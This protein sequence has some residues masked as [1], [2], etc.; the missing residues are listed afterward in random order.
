MATPCTAIRSANNDSLVPNSLDHTQRFLHHFASER[1]FHA[2]SRVT[3]TE[4]L[5]SSIETNRTMNFTERRS[6]WR[7]Q[8]IASDTDATKLANSGDQPGRFAQR[9]RV[10]AT[11]P[12]AEFKRTFFILLAA[13]VVAQGVTG[14]LSGQ[15]K[16]TRAVVAGPLSLIAGLATVTLATMILGRYVRIG[17]RTFR[18]IAGI[19]AAL[20]TFIIYTGSAVRLTGSGLGCPDWPTCEKGQVVPESGVHAQIEFGNRVVTGLCVLVA[21]IGVLT[22]LVRNPYRRDLVQ[23]GL[24]V[25]LAIFGNAIV[26]GFTVLSGLRPEFVLSHFVLALLALGIALALFHRAGEPGQSRALTGKDQT[27]S[28]DGATTRLARALTVT[29][30]TVLFMGMIVTGSGPHGGSDKENNPVKRFPFSTYDTSKIHSIIVWIALALVI[31]LAI[32]TT[33]RTGSTSGTALPQDA[34][35]PASSPHPVRYSARE[36]GRSGAVELRRRLTTLM[37]VIL[38][39]GTIGYIQYFNGVPALLVQFHV[40]GATAFF[41][42]VFWV[43][44]AVTKPSCA[45]A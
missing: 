9:V 33:Q 10:L 8:A 31:I 28:V 43:R 2:R 13:L 45:S 34:I 3:T 26:G 6:A 39:Q 7:N 29:A 23:F 4:L 20:L 35:E 24:L 37:G 40:V 41:I 19:S 21:G 44:A 38:A 32:R 18:I 1:H 12:S 30:A 22:A 25:S 42:A 5:P 11:M 15:S 16:T 36:N 27:A 14:A 17:M